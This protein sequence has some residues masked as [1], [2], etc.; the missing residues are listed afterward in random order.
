[1]HLRRPAATVL[2]IGLLSA[3]GLDNGPGPAPPPR[4][5]DATRF[6]D[7]IIEAGMARDWERLCA[8]ATGTC[9]GE[10]EGVEDLAPRTRPTIAAAEVHQPVVSGDARTSG[11]VLFVLCGRDAQGAPYESEVLVFD[12]AGRGLLAAAAVYWIGT[13]VSFPAPREGVTVGT[14]PPA[15]APRC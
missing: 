8:N 1:M 4:V 11:G 2:V 9:E 3:C 12:D 10:L 7:V 5:A 15:G 14:E 6:L 13:E